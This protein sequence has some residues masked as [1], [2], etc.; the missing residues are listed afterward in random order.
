MPRGIVMNVV[1]LL[2]ILGPHGVIERPHRFAFAENLQRD[3]LPDV[4]LR[5]AVDKQTPLRTHHV[6]KAG[7]NRLPVNIPFRLAPRIAQIPDRDNRVAV[8]GHAAGDAGSATA[9][10]NAAIS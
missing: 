4:A 1:F 6:D 2:L 5:T 8:D 7:S 10:A 3:S 9:V